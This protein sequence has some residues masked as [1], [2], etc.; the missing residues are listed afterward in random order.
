MDTD[1]HIFEQDI[2]ST[3]DVFGERSGPLTPERSLMLAVLEEAARCFLNYGTAQGKQRVLYDEARDW[4]A[5]SDHTRLY[6]FE[7]ICHVLGIEPDYLRRRLI[8]VRDRRQAAAP[9]VRPDR[10]ASAAARAE[11]EPTED[12]QAAG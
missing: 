12:W 8:E 6:D 3:A 9:R 11:D 1:N 7:N 4:F 10:A 2:V 5:S